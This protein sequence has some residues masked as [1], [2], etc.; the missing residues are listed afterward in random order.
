MDEVWKKYFDPQVLDRLRGLRLR[1]GRVASGTFVGAHRTPQ[2]GQAVEFSEYRQYTTG[3]D[4]RQVDWKIYGR[5]DKFYLR[6]REDETTLDCEFLVDSSGSMAYASDG[7]E[8]DKL[9]YAQRVVASL[10]YIAVENH[11]R[12]SLTTVGASVVPRLPAGSGPGQLMALANAMDA[13]HPERE[14]SIADQLAAVAPTFG[15]PGLVVIASDFFDD[16]ESL[17]KTIRGISQAAGAVLAIQIVDPAE[18]EF[19]FGATTQ[20]IGLEEEESLT[21]DARGIAAA[22]REEFRR[23]QSRIEAG[24]RAAEV[25]L[26]SLTTDKPL[27]AVL[28]HL[29]SSMQTH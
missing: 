11:D 22:Y 8:T 20:F 17:L 6:R 2:S 24:C 14:A 4:L 29:V 23:H 21:A 19:P 12:V 10:A 16:A 18:V 27:H 15:R 1:A 3:D 26:W 25:T 13:V 28:P 7:A 9:T 5:T